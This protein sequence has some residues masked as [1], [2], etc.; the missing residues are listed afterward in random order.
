MVEERQTQDTGGFPIEF[1]GIKRSGGFERL[2]VRYDQHD[3]VVAA[4]TMPR[5]RSGEPPQSNMTHA[6]D[7]LLMPEPLLTAFS[8]T[9]VTASSYLR[10][11]A[12]V[13]YI[14]LIQAC[15]FPRR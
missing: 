4:F 2:R 10:C 15:I 14:C 12:H 3:F 9:V 5:W 13:L 1:E 7:L 6:N 8:R 11:M